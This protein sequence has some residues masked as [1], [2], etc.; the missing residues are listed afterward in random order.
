MEQCSLLDEKYPLSL[1]QRGGPRMSLATGSLSSGNVSTSIIVRADSS[2]DPGADT[3][4]AGAAVTVT[5]TAT[6]AAGVTTG[7]GAAM[8]SYTLFWGASYAAAGNA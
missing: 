1:C 8:P 5:G 2:A 4:T 7:C 3:G 6:A